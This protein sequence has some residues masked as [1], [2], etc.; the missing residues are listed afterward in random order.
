MKEKDT[1]KQQIVD[2]VVSNQ[3][4][5]REGKFRLAER[6]LDIL[7][8]IFEQMEAGQIDKSILIDLCDDSN[9]Y[10]RHEA[11]MLMMRLNYMIERAL[12]TLISI[13]ESNT[14][15][16]SLVAIAQ[17]QSWRET[18]SIDPINAERRANV[19]KKKNRKDTLPTFEISSAKYE[20]LN[21]KQRVAYLAS[22]YA[23]EVNNGG[24]YQYFE[25]KGIEHVKETIKSLKIIGARKNADILK[26]AYKQYVSEK[27][28]HPETVT[29]F[30]AEE[31]KEEFLEYDTAFYNTEPEIPDLIEI[32][33]EENEL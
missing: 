14:L 33:L 17:I 13:A 16:I 30:V 23:N 6:Q 15:V 4:L 22:I 25:N 11:A 31:S 1:I 20:E 18:G 2:A 27:R 19:S 3:E 32:Y 9:I 28:Q 21:D 10:V 12:D 26:K 29:A 5:G 24:H 8:E 7:H